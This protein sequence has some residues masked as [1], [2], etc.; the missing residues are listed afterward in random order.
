MQDPHSPILPWRPMAL[1]LDL[2]PVERLEKGLCARETQDRHRLAPPGFQTF[3]AMEIEE[4][5][6]WE[7]HRDGRGDADPPDG[8]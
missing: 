7:A 6:G 3:L 5:A 4:K 1:G 8:V 2:K